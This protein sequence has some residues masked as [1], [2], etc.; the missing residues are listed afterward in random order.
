VNACEQHSSALSDYLDGDE[1]FIQVK[2]SCRVCIAT[3]PLY[4]DNTALLNIQVK[5][6]L[7][8]SPNYAGDE[9]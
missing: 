6:Y 9:K 3:T 5:D 4:H 1:I 7:G 2:D 8:N